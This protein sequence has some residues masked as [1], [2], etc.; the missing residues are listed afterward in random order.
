MNYVLVALACLAALV[1]LGAALGVRV[2]KQYERGVV[3]RF[4][5]VRPAAAAARA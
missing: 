1:L 3:F 2:V 4:G 5:R